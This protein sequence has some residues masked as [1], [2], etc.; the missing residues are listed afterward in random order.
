MNQI[1]WL[2]FLNKKLR[3]ITLAAAL[4]CLFIPFGTQAQTNPTILVLGD[5]L[6]AEYGLA[7]GTGW[8]RLLGAQLHKESS[9]WTIFNASISGE[10]SS[11]GLSRLPKL[12][13]QKKPG[14][15]LLEL[16]AND[17][18]RGLSIQ[19]SENNLR[20]MIQLSKKSGAKVLLFGMQIPPNY[21]QAYTKQFQNLFP[22]LA[23]QEKVQLLPFFLQGVASDPTLFQAD[24]MHPNEKAQTILYKNVW[25]A[26]APYQSI[27]KSK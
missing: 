21:G 13:E 23:Q 27:F 7:R 19:E 15:V 24:R 9:P 20:K 18:L 14:I 22:E 3:A 16:G 1:V 4:F 12:L 8:V 2:S 17:A 5:S 26:M 25:G 11:G 10:T 6:S